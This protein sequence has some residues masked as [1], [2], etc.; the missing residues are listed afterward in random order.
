MATNDAIDW[1]KDAIAQAL[2]DWSKVE[3][4]AFGRTAAS[5]IKAAGKALAFALGQAQREIEV[6]EDGRI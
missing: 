4:Q 5:Q 3:Q 2:A 6:H 1:S